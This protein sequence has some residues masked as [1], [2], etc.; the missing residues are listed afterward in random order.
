M[1]TKVRCLFSAGELMQVKRERETEGER[2]REREREDCKEGVSRGNRILPFNDSF[3]LS[4]SVSQ[5][6]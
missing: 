2:E 4:L 1:W 5:P 3:L 6:L